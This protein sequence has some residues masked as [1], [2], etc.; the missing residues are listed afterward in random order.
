MSKMPTDTR[1]TRFQRLA[2]GIYWYAF[3]APP[4]TSEG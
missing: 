4:G 1:N 2:D 3:G